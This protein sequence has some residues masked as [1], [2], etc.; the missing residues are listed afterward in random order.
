MIVNEN[1]TVVWGHTLTVEFE[2]VRL[3]SG[4]QKTNLGHSAH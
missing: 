3:A 1:V 2:V 4:S